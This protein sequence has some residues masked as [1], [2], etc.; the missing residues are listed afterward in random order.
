MVRR[1]V[2]ASLVAA[3]ALWLLWWRTGQAPAVT[4]HGPV[5]HT[6]TIE[7]MRFDPEVLTVNEG[8]TVVWLNKDLFPH[9]ATS[10]VGGFD[11]R[12]IDASG[13]WRQTFKSK[14]TFFYVCTLHPPMKATIEV[15]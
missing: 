4:A 7:S 11:S 14:G 10:K 5:T 15:R 9:T 2:F 12:Q 1:L 13:S 8:D 3:G 6:V